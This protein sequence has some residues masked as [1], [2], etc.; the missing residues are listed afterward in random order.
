MPERGTAIYGRITWL[1]HFAC[2]YRCTYC[3]YHEGCGWE[4]L[5]A[6]NRYF[7]VAQWVDAWQRLYDTY[8]RFVII[9]TGGEPFIYPGFE[10]II[11]QISSQHYPINISTNASQDLERF[12]DVVDPE[13]ITLSLSFHPQFESI[14]E[15]FGKVALVRRKKFQGCL[16]LVAYPLYLNKVEYYQGYARAS[17]EQFKVI[18]FRGI[19]RQNAYPWSYSDEELERAG[20]ETDWFVKVRRKGTYCQAGVQSALLLPD[21]QVAKCGQMFYSG[22]IGNFFD[23]EFRLRHEAAQCEREMCPCAEDKIFGEAELV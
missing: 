10:N 5:K 8:G 2:N 11:Q 12:T 7:S 13:R 14:E 16:N 17:S 19:Y 23:R 15:F 18:P 21:G 4:I 1:T 6:Q 22:I 9:A 3:F 20:I